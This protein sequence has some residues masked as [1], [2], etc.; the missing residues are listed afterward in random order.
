MQSKNYEIY[1]V[2][3]ELY[4]ANQEC[5][6]N[7]IV[8]NISWE[9]NIGFGELKFMYNTKTNKWN[10]DSEC[11]GKDFCKAVLR[12]WFESVFSIKG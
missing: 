11:M 2:Q 9:A 1:S 3:S 7:I 6:P 4:N 8:F 5:F 12:K 10:Y